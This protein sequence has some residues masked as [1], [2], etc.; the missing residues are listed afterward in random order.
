[1]LKAGIIFNDDYVYTP[2]DF[3]RDEEWFINMAWTR[4]RK[5]LRKATLGFFW[6]DDRTRPVRK[7]R[8]DICP[9]L[10][11]PVMI[12]CEHLV[13]VY[14][15]IFLAGWNI[16]F[17][18][19]TERLLWRITTSTMLGFG[20]LGG[21]LFFFIDL[22]V[23]RKQQ[24]NAASNSALRTIGQSMV[25]WL[26]PRSML[27]QVDEG[28]PTSMGWEDMYF[29]RIPKVPRPL[30]VLAATMSVFYFWTRLFVLVEDFVSLRSL[31][32]S[33]FTTVAWTRNL[34][35]S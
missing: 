15:A 22:L 35:H 24:R 18:T 31:P 11:L 32:E 7:L 19:P 26:V 5:F 4:G 27:S 17:P 33:A 20:F 29:E 3:L 12:V 9:S 34:P 13:I 21:W 16:E 25:G 28:G 1:M 23:V 8:S 14:S 30:L 2:L 6:N 10:S